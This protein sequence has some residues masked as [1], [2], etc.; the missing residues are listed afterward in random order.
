MAIAA[1]FFAGIA[2]TVFFGWLIL[3]AGVTHPVYAWSKAKLR[4]P[5][6]SSKG[7]GAAKPPRQ[8]LFE[9]AKG[10]VK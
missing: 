2:A 8:C 10:G 1:P 7:I 6:R 5:R 9:H 3:F 4:R